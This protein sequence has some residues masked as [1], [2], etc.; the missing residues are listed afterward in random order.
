MRS[1]ADCL[2]AL[3]RCSCCTAM[4]RWSADIRISSATACAQCNILN[5]KSCR[6]CAEA[7]WHHGVPVPRWLARPLLSI[8]PSTALA[9]PLAETVLL[10]IDARSCH[11]VHHLLQAEGCTGMRSLAHGDAT[12]IMFSCKVGSACGWKCWMLILPQRHNFLSNKS[13]LDAHQCPPS[14]CKR[15]R[16]VDCMPQGTC[17]HATVGGPLTVLLG[18]YHVQLD[19]APAGA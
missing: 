2:L 7:S 3:K 10:R 5:A 6:L 12:S 15:G 13:S 18:E 8:L 14:G 19:A 4:L 16:Q 1:T 17:Q 9:V 11:D